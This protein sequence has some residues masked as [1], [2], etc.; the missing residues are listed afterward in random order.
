M[1]A[2]MY[3]QVS[4][5]GKK[6]ESAIPVHKCTGMLRDRVGGGA[7]FRARASIAPRLSCFGESVG[8]GGGSFFGEQGGARRDARER[9]QRMAKVKRVR[10]GAP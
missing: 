8:R 2:P 1:G 5:K 7:R 9:T 3:P 6:G 10:G 4:K